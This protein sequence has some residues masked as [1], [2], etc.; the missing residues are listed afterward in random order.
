[1]IFITLVTF[2]AW[3]FGLWDDIYN[4]SNIFCMIILRQANLK[5]FSNHGGHKCIFSYLRQVNF[6]IFSN[7]GGQFKYIFSCW[8]TGALAVD[9][10]KTLFFKLKIPWKTLIFSLKIPWKNL[11][12][13]L[14]I[15]WKPLI[16]CL[17]LLVGTLFH[18]NFEF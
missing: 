3:I 11:I 5:I 17:V 12:F 18:L 2:S 8:W 13:S 16:F 9:T 10:L 7:H 4:F 6:K 14:K 15:P 1:M